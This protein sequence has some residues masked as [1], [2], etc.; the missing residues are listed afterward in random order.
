MT[1]RSERQ[2]LEAQEGEPL[3]KREVMSIITPGEP[4]PLPVVE[5]GA[6]PQETVKPDTVREP[7]G[8]GE[9]L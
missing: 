1:D 5:A 9:E 8:G 3:P 4:Q 6:E 2:D 7:L